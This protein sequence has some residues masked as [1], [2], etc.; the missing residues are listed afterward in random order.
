MEQEQG[1]DKEYLGKVSAA[2]YEAQTFLA[3]HPE[4][5]S[6]PENGKIMTDYMAEKNLILTA[7]N[8]EYAFEKLK[9]RGK[10]LPAK[11][12]LANMSADEFKEFVDKNG[13]PTYDAF[14]RE[15]KELPE[16]YLTESTVDYNRGR[17]KPGPAQTMRQ[18]RNVT[19]QGT[20]PWEQ[21]K[22][23]SRETYATMSSDDLGALHHWLA[24][25][26]ISLK[27]VLR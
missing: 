6:T 7:E 16:V 5:F 15:R 22:K 13:V 11:E 21:G 24:E 3:K 10:L 1:V 26:G 23:I 25:N 8:F 19:E 12:A 27:E 17:Q 9:Q 18:S 20:H 4:F 14:G 2:R